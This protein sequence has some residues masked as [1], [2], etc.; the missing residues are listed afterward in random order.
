MAT[1]MERRARALEHFTILSYREWMDMR[2]PMNDWADYNAE[3][4][5]GDII[6]KGAYAS[7]VS[8]KATELAS[9]ERK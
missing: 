9:L 8:R 6:L 3:E 5:L 7:Y 1:K 2:Y 4:T